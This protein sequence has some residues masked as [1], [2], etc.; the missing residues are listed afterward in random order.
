MTIVEQLKHMH[1]DV[2]DQVSYKTGLTHENVMEIIF[3]TGVQYIERLAGN[4]LADTFLKEPLFW[5]WWQQ[6]WS[7]MDQLFLVKMKGQHDKDDIQAI[8]IKFHEDIDV[9]P[10]PV[11]WDQIHESYQKMSQDVITKTRSHAQHI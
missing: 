1:Q 2:T 6:Q 3:N 8:Y 9:Y 4:Q 10:D 5:A 11:I 7:M